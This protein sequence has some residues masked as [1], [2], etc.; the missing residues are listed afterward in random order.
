[1]M[2]G[3]CFEFLP[4][5]VIL[6]C[7]RETAGWDGTVATI[8]SLPDPEHPQCLDPLTKHLSGIS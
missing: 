6:C 1:M 3:D 7:V 8:Q 2:K 4:S 5:V